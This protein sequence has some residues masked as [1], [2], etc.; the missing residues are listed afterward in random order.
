MS[1]THILLALM[2]RIKN[3]RGGVSIIRRWLSGY[4]CHG[5][6]M[7][8]QGFFSEHFIA[9][10]RLHPVHESMHACFCMVTW[11][12]GVVC[13]Y[14]PLTCW[15]WPTWS[16]PSW[17]NS[18]NSRSTYWF[19]K[20]R[21]TLWHDPHQDVLQDQVVQVYPGVT[22]SPLLMLVERIFFLLHIYQPFLF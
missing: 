13:V 1:C 17:Q 6:K 20:E 3:E 12:A 15:Q 7:Q 19:D 21:S 5:D 22:T 4:C 11:L 8:V 9:P 10:K 2:S 14:K 18:L 16:V